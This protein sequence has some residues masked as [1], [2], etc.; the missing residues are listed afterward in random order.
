MYIVTLGTLQPLQY[1]TIEEAWE[2]RYLEGRRGCTY[3]CSRGC[4]CKAFERFKERLT[5]YG[6]LKLHAATVTYQLDTQ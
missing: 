6:I 1:Y 2:S 5:T 4:R 3:L